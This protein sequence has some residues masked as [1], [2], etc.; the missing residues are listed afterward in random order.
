MCIIY[1]PIRQ[2]QGQ[3]DTARADI[4]NYIMDRH[5]IKSRINHMNTILQR[6]AN[7]QTEVVSNNNFKQNITIAKQ[8]YHNFNTNNA[9]K[10]VINKLRGLESAS[11][12]YR[13]SDRHLLTKFSANFCG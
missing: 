3:L 9:I 1:V 12:L 7:K 10:L 11:E 4:R 13:L 2:L 8:K 5:N 6:I